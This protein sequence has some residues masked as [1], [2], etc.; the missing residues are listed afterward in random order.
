[1]KPVFHLWMLKPK[2]QSSGCTHI[3]ETSRRSL[4]K[5]C[6][7]ARK[8]MA[9]VFWDMKGVLT[10]E[11]IQ[12]TTITSEVYCGTFKK[13]HRAIQNNRCGMLTSDVV[14]PNDNTRSHTS[15]CTQAL[16]EHFNWSCLTSLL[17]ALISLL[18]TTTHLPTWRTGCDYGASTIMRSWWKV[19]KRGWAHRWQTSLTKAYKSLFPNTSD[20]ILVV[21]TLRSSISMY[22][23]Y[24]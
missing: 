17:T 14:H 6:L 5:C 8:L 16:L 10:V 3:H 7:P 20:S 23:V 15:A 21:T 13:L 2:S 18:A 11:F 19:L 24:A 22:Q 9:A 12:G 4:N 1:M